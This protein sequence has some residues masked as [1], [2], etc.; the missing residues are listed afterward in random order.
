MIQPRHMDARGAS[1]G[2]WTGALVGACLTVSLTAVLYLGW[3]LA[4][5]PFVPFDLFDWVARR[6]PGPVVTLAI[7]TMVKI[8][9]ALGLGSTAD[10]AKAAEQLMAAAGFLVVGMVGGAVLFTVLRARRDASP[11]RAGLM[12]GAVV[13]VPA[14]LIGHNLTGTAASGPVAAALWT[15]AAFLAWGAAF[16]WAHERLS[17]SAEETPLPPVP[18]APADADVHAS[19]AALASVERLDRRRFLIRLGGAAAAIT[20]SGAVVG[21]LVRPSRRGSVA[22]PDGRWSATQP[23]PN[24]GAAVRPAPGTRPEFTPLEQHYRID[25]NLIPKTIEEQTWRLQVRGL[26]DAPVD[27]TLAQIHRF[28]PTHQFVTL[29][30]IS[31]EIGGDL[32][33][34]TRWTGVSLQRLLPS[35]GLRPDATHL[36]IRSADGFFEVVALDVIMRDERVMLAYAWDGVP[37]RPQH[38]FPLRIYVPDLYGMKQPK[39]ITAIEAIARWEPG[40]WVVRGWDREARM[41]AT[42]VIDTVAVDAVTAGV[43]GT[44][45]VPIGGIAHAGARGISKVE[46]RVDDGGWHP[47]QLRAPVSGTTWVIWRY[48]WAF[49][50]GAHTLAV[51]CHDGSGAMQVSEPSTPHPSGATGLHGRRVRL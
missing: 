26:V 43:D 4:G 14:A 28:P 46:V 40:Y 23:L 6:L 25:I 31:N 32:I 13:G 34:T 50:P 15:L 44:K 5:L 18:G 19:P 12:L 3:K 7:A 20:V 17:P 22:A 27:L 47:A 37:L 35:L 10:V 8:I 24:A 11:R 33:G 48:D 16:G 9:G 29:S 45:F 1:P 36:K 30:C 2:G 51:R 42:S 21:A 41:K 38:G 39:W 49:L